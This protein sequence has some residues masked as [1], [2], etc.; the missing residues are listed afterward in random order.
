MKVQQGFIGIGFLRHS[1][2]NLRV[3]VVN[4]FGLK[5]HETIAPARQ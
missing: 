3:L 4:A 2:V 5:K 1:F